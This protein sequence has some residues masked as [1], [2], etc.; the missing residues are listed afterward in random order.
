M[1]GTRLTGP[2]G[3]VTGQG[4]RARSLRRRK[5]IGA[6]ITAGALVASGAVS[7]VVTS[8]VPAAA[9]SNAENAP[10]FGSGTF[11]AYAEA[12]DTVSAS[13][14]RPGAGD[15]GTY[16]FELTSPDGVVVWECTISGTDP[17]GQTCEAPAQTAGSA[18]AW[19]VNIVHDVN[20]G[21]AIEWDISV[22]DANGAPQPGRVWTDRYRVL[23]NAS[24]TRDLSYHL[25][26]DTGYL[27][28]LDLGG[29]NGINS[30]T[31][32][33]SVGLADPETCVPSYL[34]RDRNAGDFDANCG[35]D[36]RIFFDE[37]SADLPAT[38][39]SPDGELT[40]LPPPLTEDDLAVDDLAFAPVAPDAAEGTFTYSLNPRFQGAYQLQIDTDGNGSYDDEVDRIIELSADGSSSY[41]YDF[42]GT[43]GVGNAVP[44]CTAMNARIYFDRVGEVHVLQ[45]DVEAR[46][47][48]I[49]LTRTNGAG[50]PDST[51]YWDDRQLD[52]AGHSNTTPVVNGT[53]GV[54]STGGVHGWGY[55]E[56]SWGNEVII[57][58]WAYLP[59]DLGS[60]E[61]AIGSSCLTVEKTSDATENSRVGDTVTYTVTATNSGNSDFTAEAPASVSDDLTGVLDDATYN[62]DATADQEGDLTYTDG[63]LNWTGALPAGESVTI[64]YTVELTAGGD[65]VVRNVAFEGTP[66]TPVPDCDPPNEDGKDPETGVACAETENLLPRLTI[67]KTADRTDLPAEGETATFTVTVTNEGPGDYTE[68]APATMTDDL[69]DV[70]DD[71]N[72]V[73]GSLSA[74]TGEA[75]FADGTVSWSGPLAAGESATI[76]YTVSYTGAGDNVLLNRACVPESEVAPGAEPC[77]E[78]Q[79][80]GEVLEPELDLVKSSSVE[81]ISEVGQEITYSFLVTNTGAVTVE[82]VTVNEGA[83]SGSGELSEVTCPEEAAS[84]APGEDVTCT[85]TYTVTQAD[86]D[87]G[88]L[89]NT[90]TATG[91]TPGGDPVD[92]PPSDVSTPGPDPE[93]DLVKTSDVEEISEVGQEITYS[94]LVTNTGVVTVEDVTVNEGAFSGSGEL[95]EVTCPEEAASL[96][97]GEDVTCTATYTVTEA[98]VA[99]GDL[100][101]TATA[102]GTTPGGDPVDSPPSSVIVDNGVP[103]V[104]NAGGDDPGSATP[105]KLPQTGAQIAALMSLA[106]ILL[107]AGAFAVRHARRIRLG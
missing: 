90:A 10:T 101:N 81:E 9:E 28:D 64:T 31:R 50:S 78:V 4:V 58:D 15:A 93:L 17:A 37:P 87:S 54:D 39:A 12:G 104:A 57:D 82:D 7:A 16:Q 103:P 45:D 38:T 105:G 95:S 80:P 29:Y 41:S 100:K 79:I 21:Q 61:I 106:L 19:R 35:T 5:K 94:F 85:A 30:L 86:L 3:P 8:A 67:E 74:S 26:N 2:T 71:A 24:Q 89:E 55:S 51:I 14:T 107:V 20:G 66:E 33:N 77:D 46:T 59:L 27:Y 102:T 65:G 49:E 75:N 70:L 60:G 23:Q 22:S 88:E 98:D 96:A 36:F 97:P 1:R 92:S 53:A 42:D 76:T 99:A 40:V 63:R 43:D 69:S 34:S 68:D 73:D 11:Y 18:G 91:T 56:T 25:V 44:E 84:L 52:P 72:I 48:G 62:D 6:L 47:G 83:F 13:F 32:A